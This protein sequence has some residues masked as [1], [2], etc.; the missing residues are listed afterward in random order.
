MEKLPAVDWNLAARSGAGL[1]PAGPGLSPVEIAGV[2]AELRTAAAAATEQVRRVTELPEPAPVSVLVLDRGGWITAISQSAQAMLEGATGPAEPASNPYRV[3]RAKVLGVEAGAVFAGLAS[4]V[5]GQFDPYYRPE[6][7]LLVAPNVVANEQRF[8]VLPRDFRLWVCLH[9]E[10]HRFQF[11]VAPWLRSHFLGLI[12]ELLDG[13]ELQFGWRSG[14]GFRPRFESPQQQQV[15]DQVNAVMALLEGYADVMM[16]RVGT[17]VVPTY[18]SIRRAFNAHRDSP[19]M[20]DVA[21]R[22]LGLDLKMAQY[23]EGAAFCQAVIEA[24]GVSTL[25]QAFSAPGL[26]P[27]TAE[28]RDPQRWLHR[29]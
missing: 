9:E 15:F 11:G 23:R 25:N 14:D 24:A 29:L 28:L 7:L 18:P 26:L 13:Q 17:E 10:T 2:V 1:V 21:Q 5:L 4:R 16:D 6:R 22:L 12:G 3:A 27:T 20:F 8:G 19:G